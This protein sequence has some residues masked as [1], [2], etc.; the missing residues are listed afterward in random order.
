MFIIISWKFPENIYH[1][2]TRP[3]LPVDGSEF[4][5]EIRDHLKTKFTLK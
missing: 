5:V 3:D 1:D 2:E 4:G